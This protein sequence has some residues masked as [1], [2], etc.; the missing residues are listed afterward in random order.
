VA[1]V[2]VQVVFD[3]GEECM[4]TIL[5]AACMALHRFGASEEWYSGRGVDVSPHR[6]AVS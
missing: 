4:P 6:P 2:G 1:A 3:D 5:L